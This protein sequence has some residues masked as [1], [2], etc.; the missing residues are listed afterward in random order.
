MCHGFSIYVLEEGAH[1]TLFHKSHTMN[2][3]QSIGSSDAWVPPPDS[4]AYIL[5]PLLITV[6]AIS[7]MLVLLRLITRLFLTKALGIDDLL[8]FASLVSS[9]SNSLGIK[10][11][12]LRPTQA[13]IGA[14]TALGI[15]SRCYSSVIHRLVG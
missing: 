15:I 4:R 14:L 12:R 11:W 1:G 3:S 7:S 8:S 6:M 13:I 2:S 10:G 9:S 5:T